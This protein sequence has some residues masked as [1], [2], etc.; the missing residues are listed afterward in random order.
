MIHAPPLTMM[1]TLKGFVETRFRRRASIWAA[2]IGS[3]PL[4]RPVLPS[5]KREEGGRDCSC[6][7]CNSAADEIFVL[8][9]VVWWCW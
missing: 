9:V 2:C 4:A 8:L 3:M 1:H 6:C 7:T 5:L